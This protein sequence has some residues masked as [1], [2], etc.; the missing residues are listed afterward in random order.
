MAQLVLNREQSREIDRRA[1]EQLRISGCVLMENAGRGCV[2]VL[3][4]LG[5][6]GPIVVLCG[7]GNNAGDG[8]V[9]AR[10][11]VV[12]GHDCRVVLLRPTDELRG[13]AA[14]N[15]AILVHLDVKFI[16]SPAELNAIR[17]DWVV[18][19]MLGTGAT[20]EPLAPFD[21]AIDWMN[22][23]GCKKLAVDVPSGLDC[24]TGQ[25]AAH[26]VRADHTCTFAAMKVGFTQPSAKPFTGT[27]HVCDIGV[28][29]NI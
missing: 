2:D 8:F 11:L 13:D 29:A 18:D 14:A 23:Q 3:E 21:K 17:V 25:P 7:K 22:A 28:P 20:G 19:A 15:H 10:H 9:I 24:D 5:I 4:R 1:I 6:A 26:T 16:S 27:V 12:R